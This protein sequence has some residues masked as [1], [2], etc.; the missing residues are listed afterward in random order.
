MGIRARVELTDKFKI[1]LEGE[2]WKIYIA[3][4]RA[5]ETL[6]NV[7]SSCNPKDIEELIKKWLTALHEKLYGDIN[8]TVE[9]V[10]TIDDIDDN[11]YEED[12]DDYDDETIDPL[13]KDED[14]TGNTSINTADTDKVK[15]KKWYAVIIVPIDNERAVHF[16]VWGRG[17]MDPDKLLRTIEEIS[18]KLIEERPYEELRR[19]L[20]AE[21]RCRFEIESIAKEV[22]KNNGF[23]V[24]NII[25][26]IDLNN[27]RKK[28]TYYWDVEVSYTISDNKVNVD[29]AF[30]FEDLPK[31]VKAAKGA[32]KRFAEAILLAAKCGGAPLV[33]EI[34]R[35]ATPRN[36]YTKRE[37]NCVRVYTTY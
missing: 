23:N 7:S 15:I 35:D 27:Y 20:D 8:I 12:I 5:E 10:E 26:N 18:K 37:I 34:V 30:D 13:C 17:E 11:D 3:M 29:V 28:E 6:N 24:D 32:L 4:K 2:L 1:T 22:L 16:T 36:I 21:S 9:K 14:D 19:L 25:I 31:N 33:E